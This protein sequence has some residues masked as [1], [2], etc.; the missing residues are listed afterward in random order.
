MSEEVTVR[1]ETV[2]YHVPAKAPAGLWLDRIAGIFL[3]GR[4]ALDVRSLLR[5][6]NS[7]PP[8]SR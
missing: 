2:D 8:H 1:L 3:D 7:R 5:D 6:L 4:T